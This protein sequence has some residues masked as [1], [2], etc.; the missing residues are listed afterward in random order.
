M[1]KKELEEYQKVLAYLRKQNRPYSAQDITS[2]LNKEV[3][4]TAVQ[5]ALDMYVTEKKVKEKVY[6]K[7]KVYCI[8]QSI[9]PNLSDSEVKEL[10]AEIL[11][12][13]A[14]RVSL[15]ESVKA[16][17]AELSALSKELTLE[18]A[19]AKLIELTELNSELEARLNGIKS[20]GG[21]QI[22]QSEKSRIQNH[23]TTNVTHWR[24]RKRL[25]SD[26]L[27]QI[28]ENYPKS[29]RELFDEIGVETDE[30]HDVKIPVT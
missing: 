30:D 10:D 12:C 21:K 15:K 19:K 25:A 28:L 13:E 11:N 14:K 27:D 9:M 24:K 7:T 1:S 23:H 29:K 6:N 2:N 17:E 18:E 4:K 26:M 8:D 5:R 16:L 20:S 22:T 3:G